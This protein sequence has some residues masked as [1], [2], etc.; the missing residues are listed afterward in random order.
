MEAV[1]IGLTG[2]TGYGAVH[3]DAAAALAR[4]GL[5]EVAAY[6]DTNP[7]PPGA[8]VLQ[9]LGARQYSNLESMLDSE[10]ELD[11]VCIATP[12]PFHFEMAQAVLSRGL[13]AFLE[14]P[15]VVRIQDLTR[16]IELEEAHGCFC[17]VGF[18]DMARPGIINLKHR[19]CEGA[20]GRVRAIHAHSRWRRNAAYYG[21]SAWAG[22]A[23]LNGAYVLDGPMNNSCAHAL[24]T[25]AYLA[26]AEP[27]E[28]ATPEWVQGELYR[29]API[30]GED[31]DC[32]RARMDSGVD[33]CIHLTQA[34]AANHQR[35][36]RVIGE[37]GVVEFQDRGPIDLAGEHIAHAEDEPPTTTLLRRLVDVVRG[38][39]E[40]LLM[41]LAETRGFV[42]LS[43][44]AYESAGTIAPVPPEFVEET[45]GPDGKAWHVRHLDDVMLEAATTGRLLSECDLPWARKTEPFRLT[46]YHR[47]P[48]RWIPGPTR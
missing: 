12:I 46:G 5:V 42:L 2:V 19:L 16:L 24:N 39:D 11:L 10:P 35:T 14:K 3:V 6:A 25:V 40:P 30:E 8:D 13:H 26:G 37:K 4:E 31:I 23:T 27:Y 28:F 32:L 18:N 15:P 38:S 21:R 29:A 48:N 9:S 43:N 45:D 41:P 47:F 17:A 36:Y 33:V 22:T 44:G 34:A 7:T 1:R 20:L